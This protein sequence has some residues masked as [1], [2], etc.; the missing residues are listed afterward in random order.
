MQRRLR[1][2]D[3]SA[4]RGVVR[5]LAPLTAILVALAACLGSMPPAAAQTAQSRLILILSDGSVSPRGAPIERIGNVYF[6]LA[7][8]EAWG[9]DGIV[10][11][12]SHA[13]LDGRGHRL[14][15]D[16]TRGTSGILVRG[17]GVVV[18]NLYIEGFQ[19]GVLVS[20]ASNV[21]AVNLTVARCSEGVSVLN[22]TD[23]RVLGSSLANNI[24]GVNA[25]FSHNV[26]VAGNS[27]ERGVWGVYVANVTSFTLSRN[28][29][30]NSSWGLMLLFSPGAKLLENEFWGCGIYSIAS[31]GCYAVDNTVNGKPLI[32]LEGAA[33][34]EVGEAGQV[35]LV[36]CTSV[37]VSKLSIQ[38]A[39]VGILLYKTKQSIVESCNLT[40][41]IWGVMLHGSTNNTLAANWV[42]GNDVGIYLYESQGNAIFEN[43]LLRNG[44]G[45]WLACSSSNRIY[46]NCF[47]LNR[48]QASAGC[49][50]NLWQGVGGG[51]YWSDADDTDLNDD[52]IADRPH[53]VGW[54]NIDEKPLTACPLPKVLQLPPPACSL[55]L[56]GNATLEG[57]ESFAVAVKSEGAL[58]PKALRFTLQAGGLSNKTNWLDWD[59]S[60]GLWDAILKTARLKAPASG[61]VI[62]EVDVKDAA[63]R[64]AKCSI[65]VNVP[66]ASQPEKAEEGGGFKYVDAA[67]IALATL[68]AAAVAMKILKRGKAGALC[69]STSG[70]RPCTPASSRGA[71]YKLR[72]LPRT[73]LR[74]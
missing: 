67:L 45:L 15:G 2:W 37:R 21:E 57:A 26:E 25:I 29:V 72:E 8:L 23:V 32:Y 62:V 63:G 18:R 59:R 4:M 68:V 30:A 31:L 50:E 36:N 49:G 43:V 41:N 53:K 33:N 34:V 61:A 20:A 10:I 40:G 74:G 52:G 66:G 44:L 5:E 51:N 42:E 69:P 46:G 38:K 47:I 60:E 70:G 7:D 22:S 73:G 28:R 9:S 71:S 35:V 39:S 55:T 19:R 6:L 64:T 17:V 58:P 13:V 65:A 24:A 16:G 48:M 3:E 12:A 1:P 54:G 56:K 11:E 14:V 27:I